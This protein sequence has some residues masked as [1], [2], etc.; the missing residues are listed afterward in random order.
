MKADISKYNPCSEAVKFYSGYKTFEEAWDNCPRGDW[1]L[2]IAQRVGVNKRKMT[3]VKA[4]CAETVKHLMNDERSLNALKV[5]KQYGRYKANDSQLKDAYTAADA[6]ASYDAYAAASYA[7]ASYAAYA[8]AS[9]AAAYDA[10][11]AAASY[12]AAYDAAAS[13]AADTA[14]YDAAADA[15]KL[16]NQLETANICRKILTKDVLRLINK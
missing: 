14:A 16:K 1:M 3:L 7:A 2:W 4:L 9:Y 12:A 8:A 11:Y 10:A 6:A 5:A 15:A 13:Y